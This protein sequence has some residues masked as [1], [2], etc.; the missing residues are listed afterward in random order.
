MAM[1]TA[2]AAG[3]IMATAAWSVM[4][5]SAPRPIMA[6]AKLAAAWPIMGLYGNVACFGSVANCGYNT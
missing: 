1:A 2:S 5:A 4:M 3:E 6:M